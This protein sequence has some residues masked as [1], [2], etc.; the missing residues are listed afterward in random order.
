MRRAGGHVIPAG[1]KTEETRTGASVPKKYP[2]QM[3]DKGFTY[4]QEIQ[5]EK[6]ITHAVVQVEH[7]QLI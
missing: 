6:E 5:R 1:G 3:K 2:E 4:D 7:G